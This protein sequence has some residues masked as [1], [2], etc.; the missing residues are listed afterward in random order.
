[1]RRKIIKSIIVLIIAIII[2]II[3]TAFSIVAYS[4][5]DESRNCDVI[6]VLG[7]AAYNTGPSPVYRER[8]NH[9]ILLYNQEFADTIIVTGGIVE[10]NEYSDAYIGIEYLIKNGIPSENIILEEESTITQENLENAKEIM[11]EEGFVTA[12]IV[13]DPLH[14]KRAMYLCDRSGI[15]GY[16]SP[17]KTSMYKSVSTKS[18]FLFREL[19]YYI[20]YQIV[21]VFN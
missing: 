1:M 13:S 18:E 8:L 6:I 16:S 4:H 14:M 10:G 5:K 19:F 7:A 2:Y 9:A 11:N 20:G 15:D 3:I 21:D 17:T 12:L